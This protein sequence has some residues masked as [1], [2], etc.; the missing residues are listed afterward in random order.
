MRSACRRSHARNLSTASCHASAMSVSLGLTG[1]AWGRSQGCIRLGSGWRST[2]TGREL[3]AHP[4]SSAL[5]ARAASVRNRHI[6]NLLAHLLR[7]L[8]E[9]VDVGLLLLSELGRHRGVLSA[10]RL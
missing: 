1:G 9:F 7:R 6:A 10:L 8:L 2:G 3:A 5:D 4:I